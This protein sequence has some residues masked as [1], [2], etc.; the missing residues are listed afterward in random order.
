MRGRVRIA[1]VA[2]VVLL[3]SIV[4]CLAQGNEENKK[5]SEELEEI[6]RRFDE[7]KEFVTGDD[8]IAVLLLRKTAPLYIH[9]DGY[10]KHEKEVYKER[11]Y[12]G[13]KTINFNKKKYYRVK[14]KELTLISVA[15]A[16]EDG[17]IR[18]MIIRGTLPDKKREETIQ[19]KTMVP[20]YSSEKIQKINDGGWK[21]PCGDYYVF[22]SDIIEYKRKLKRTGH[23]IPKNGIIELDRDEDTKN[24]YRSSFTD[25]LDMRI[26]SDLSGF[27]SEN[28]YGQIQVEARYTNILPYARS[29][30]FS[31]LSKISPF[32]TF[33]K[34]K[35]K[36]DALPV[37]GLFEEKASLAIDLKYR[38]SLDEA[39]LTRQLLLEFD[40]EMMPLSTN[41]TSFTEEAGNKWLIV[42]NDRKQRYALVAEEDKIS[43]FRGRGETSAID[44]VRY[45]D[46]NFGLDVEIVSCR[47]SYLRFR[48]GV[49][50]GLYRTPINSF[51]PPDLGS[52]VESDS[53]TGWPSI[54]R[55][56]L[57]QHLTPALEIGFTPHSAVDF[58]ISYSPI[59]IRI[60]SNDSGIFLDKLGK[61]SGLVH[62]LKWDFNIHP[63]TSDSSKSIFIKTTIFLSSV[64]ESFP[65][66][67]VGYFTPISK[68]SSMLDW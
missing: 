42:D 28:P 37:I 34:L 19:N 45:S 50:Y 17:Y 46:L 7:F 58:N 13:N 39:N 23:Y 61:R 20:V 6:K 44:L 52:K 35:S 21:Y 65:S 25:Y 14:D 22:L 24:V 54:R 36:V 29:K 55:D 9:E 49:I 30:H 1:L 31:L 8:V 43:V 53:N 5:L 62:Q 11:Y 63:D 27:Q 66:L 41:M 67:Q 4:C 51:L 2:T 40:K 59:Y 38:T 12:N 57:S 60:F 16:F 68:I 33:L 56:L 48:G 18:D 64:D 32:V 47:Y 15:I 3:G 10:K 26:Y